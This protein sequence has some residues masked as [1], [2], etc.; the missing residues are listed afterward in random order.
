MF[1]LFFSSLKNVSRKPW[2]GGGEIVL[3]NVLSKTTFP[4]HKSIGVGL[5]GAS[6]PLWEMTETGQK[7]CF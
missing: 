3:Q 2:G 1:M 6:L 7:L 5:V 4:C